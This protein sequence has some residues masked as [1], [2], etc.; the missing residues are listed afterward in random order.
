MHI[1]FP[2]P[3]NL[4]ANMM[5]IVMGRPESVPHQLTPAHRQ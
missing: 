4:N 1:Q 5:P 3:A 2:S